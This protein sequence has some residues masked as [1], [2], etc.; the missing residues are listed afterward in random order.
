MN[1]RDGE[2]NAVPVPR[3]TKCAA[4]ARRGRVKHPDGFRV[5]IML[6]KVGAMRAGRIAL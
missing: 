4:Q 6:P 2:G 3:L 5:G 1:L